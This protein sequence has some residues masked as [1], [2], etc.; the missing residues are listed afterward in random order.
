MKMIRPKWKYWVLSKK[1]D[2][3]LLSD[4]INYGNQLRFSVI[5]QFFY[6]NLNDFE[7][8]SKISKRKIY[9]MPSNHPDPRKP[10]KVHR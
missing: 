5:Y 2:K 9:T 1:V 8:T 6:K 10:D 4:N 7:V 3:K